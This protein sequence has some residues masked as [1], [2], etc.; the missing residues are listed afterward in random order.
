MERVFEYGVT[1]CSISPS[2]CRSEYCSLRYRSTPFL[3]LELLLKARPSRTTS[4]W[5]HPCCASSSADTAQMYHLHN[6]FSYLQEEIGVN[7]RLAPRVPVNRG[8]RCLR[9]LFYIFYIFDGCKKVF[10][11]LV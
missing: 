3:Q 6:F 4:I 10:V 8:R 9:T 1:S 7:A 2:A 5:T 11:Q